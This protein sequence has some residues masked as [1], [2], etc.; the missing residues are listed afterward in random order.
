M[1]NEY[2]SRMAEILKGIDVKTPILVVGAGVVGSWTTLSLVKAGLYNVTVCDFDSVEDVNVGPQL[3]GPKDKGRKKVYALHDNI[4]ALTGFSVKPSDGRV[5]SLTHPFEVVILGPDSVAARRDILKATNRLRNNVKHLFDVRTGGEAGSLM[6]VKCE[7]SL[8][9][10]T[11]P[12]SYLETLEGPE[13]S[14]SCGRRG[15]P[16]CGMMAASLTTHGV[17]NVLKDKMQTAWLAFEVME[18]MTP[19]V[20]MIAGAW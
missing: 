5:E 19:S 20:R 2:T 12:R 10:G 17:L 9:P 6:Y 8:N 18:A 14:G 4:E 7:P 13:I 16:Y 11:L 3:Y 15:T 1:T